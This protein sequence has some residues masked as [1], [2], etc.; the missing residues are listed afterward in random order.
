MSIQALSN[1]NRKC[2]GGVRPQNRSSI[3]LEQKA[4]IAGPDVYSR[5]ADPT[6]ASVGFN[7]MKL[8]VFIKS[9]AVAGLLI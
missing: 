2:M 8:I 1:Q 5:G 7:Y 6:L 9:P 3:V 4:H